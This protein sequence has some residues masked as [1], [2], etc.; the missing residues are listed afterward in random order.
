M[1][2]DIIKQI[3]SEQGEQILSEP[4]RVKAFFSDLAINEPKPQK[5]AFMLCLEHGFVKILKEIP[6]KERVNCKESLAQKLHK[7]EGLD[8]DLCKEAI[9]MLSAVL[10]AESILQ[11]QPQPQP[12]PQPQPQPKPQPPPKLQPKPQPK[13]L[14][15]TTGC[16]FSEFLSTIL[17]IFVLSYYDIFGKI[18]RFLKSFF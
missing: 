8:L 10:F 3:V 14:P 7:E 6:E 2:L 12:K 4:K 1:L 13:T 11:P 15:K 5:Q 18:F 16:W 17:I 9:A